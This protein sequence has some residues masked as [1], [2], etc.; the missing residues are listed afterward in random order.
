MNVIFQFTPEQ[1]LRRDNHDIHRNQKDQSKEYCEPSTPV[2]HR[3]YLNR[4]HK[5]LLQILDNQY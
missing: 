3:A 2:Y 4:K 5:T 1:K